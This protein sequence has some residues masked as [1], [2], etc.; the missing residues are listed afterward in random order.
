MLQAWHV[1]NLH[2]YMQNE[3]SVDLLE[4]A[5]SVIST[6]F[7]FLQKS[8]FYNEIWFS[9]IVNELIKITRIILCI[10][11]KGGFLREIQNM[12]RNHFGSNSRWLRLFLSFE[13]KNAPSFKK[14][15]SKLYYSKIS[16]WCWI[17]ATAKRWQIQNMLQM[18]TKIITK[19]IKN[20]LSLKNHNTAHILNFYKCVKVIF[21]KIHYKM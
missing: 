9:R 6:D 11:W 15:S 13:A 20:D 18:S 7:S 4:F 17:H 8:I 1:F 19:L 5:L 3:K 12:A 10:L 21:Q 14:L 2:C 16:L